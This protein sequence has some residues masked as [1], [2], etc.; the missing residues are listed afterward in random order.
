MEKSKRRLDKKMKKREQRM[1]PKDKTARVKKMSVQTFLEK[2]AEDYIEEREKME[3]QGRNTQWNKADVLK[4]KSYGEWVKMF[5]HLGDFWRQ[6]LADG[7]EA[8]NLRMMEEA[9]NK[10]N[11][12]EQRNWAARKAAE[13]AQE[14]MD[15]QQAYRDPNEDL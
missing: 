3:T 5:M 7:Q 14:L 12:E 6:F 10:K 15:M 4:N 1:N 11:A 9:R 2:A 13:K 8:E